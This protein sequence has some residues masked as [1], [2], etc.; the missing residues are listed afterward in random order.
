MIGELFFHHLLAGF[1]T[2]T[3]DLLIILIGFLQPAHRSA[4]RINHF[5]QR[6][7]RYRHH[8]DEQQQDMYDQTAGISKHL[9]QR[10]GRQTGHQSATAQLGSIEI[11]LQHPVKEI[12][13][14]RIAVKELTQSTQQNHQYNQFPHPQMYLSMTLFQRNHQR[15]C[16]TNRTTT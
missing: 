4:N 7:T 3:A 1:P 16:D 13:S 8:Q 10:P 15:H 12:F 6:R 9:H 14:C 5:Q 2:G 11:Q